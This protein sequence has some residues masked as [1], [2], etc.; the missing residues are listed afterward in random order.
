M[1]DPWDPAN[2]TLREKVVEHLF[3][4]DLSRHLLL[5]RRM[6]F[7][8]LRAEF[9]AFGYDVVVEANGVM[10]HVQMKAGR[11][12]GTNRRVEIN[13]ALVSKPGGCVVWIMIDPQTFML[14]PFYWFGGE[15]GQPLPELGD[16]VARHTRGERGE[17]KL[18]PAMR[19]LRR[20]GFRRLESLS[21]LGNALFGLGKSDKA[22][23]S[24]SSD[25]VSLDVV[26]SLK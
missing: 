24:C 4:A 8:V 10:R 18:R 26:Q 20:T 22:A 2:A 3:L 5:E 6:P 12:D 15:P 11:S 16:R 14:G 23:A 9:D 25:I 7:E 21:E 1:F 13:T 17:K 19:V